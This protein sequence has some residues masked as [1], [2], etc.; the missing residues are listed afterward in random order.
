MFTQLVIVISVICLLITASK[1]IE[2]GKIVISPGGLSLPGGLLFVAFAI[3]SYGVRDILIQFGKYDLQSIFYKIGGISQIIG[4]F[5]VGIF[6][7]G[8]LTQKFLRKILLPFWAVYSIIIIIAVLFFPVKTVIKQ[9]VLEPFPYKVISLP[10]ESAAINIFF[11]AGTFFLSLFILIT[12]LYNFINI[13]E[14]SGR[15][16]TLFYGIGLFCL[17]LPAILCVFISPIFGRLGYVV[18]AICIFLAFRIKTP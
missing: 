17:F 3:F 9:A 13:K 10:W 15:L 5:L 4:F 1:I 12:F 18:G 7:S 16:K 11:L 6:V 14:K 2:K 8:F